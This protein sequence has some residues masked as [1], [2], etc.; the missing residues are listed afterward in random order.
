MVHVG[1][2]P[3]GNRRYAKQQK[4]SKKEAYIQGF[5]VLCNMVETLWL[6]EEERR[7]KITELTVY[8]CSYDNLVKRN[9]ED[10]ENIIKTIRMFL[11][12]FEKNKQ[13]IRHNRVRVNI[14]GELSSEF[15]PDEIIEELEE[16]VTITRYNDEY[17]LN[18]AI[19]YDAK[20][21]VLRAATF[22]PKNTIELYNHLY[23]KTNIDIVLRTGY[24]KR[25]SGFFPLQTL[26]AEWFF[27]DKHWPEITIDFIQQMLIKFQERQRRMGS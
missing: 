21:E 11:Q 13:K 26:Y 22:S 10:V 15:L 18:L 16:I 20:K 23:V 19:C 7:E 4:I 3:D 8:V 12:F 1:I 5:Q 9:E 17:V 24:E 6:E 25:T 2:I 14:A 27:V